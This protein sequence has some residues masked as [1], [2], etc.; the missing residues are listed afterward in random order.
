MGIDLYGLLCVILN[1]L[2]LLEGIQFALGITCLQALF[3]MGSRAKIKVVI[4]LAAHTF[5]LEILNLIGLITTILTSYWYYN[6]VQ[7]L[8]GHLCYLFGTINH[9]LQPPPDSDAS[10]DQVY[11]QITQ[12]KSQFTVVYMISIGVLGITSIL[13]DALLVSIEGYIGDQPSYST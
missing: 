7:D 2:C 5:V 9:E 3:K 11:H 6:T 12:L 1:P 8:T 4:W 13:T 10:W